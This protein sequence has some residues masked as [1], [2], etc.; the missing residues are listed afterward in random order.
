MISIEKFVFNP[1]QENTYVLYDHT[2]ECVIVDPGCIDA[3]EQ[4]MI[5]DFIQ[6]NDLRP[7]MVLNTHLHLDHVFGCKFIIDTY[8][9]PFIAHADDQFFIDIT[10]SYAVQ[11][12]IA[13]SENPPGLTKTVDEGDVVKFGESELQIIHVPGHSPGG[14]VLYNKSQQF[15]IAGDVLFNGSIGRTDLVQGNH[16]QLIS[17]IKEKLLTLNDDIIVY[18]GH[19]GVTTIGAEKQENPFLV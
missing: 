4:Q 1:F 7:V 11:F 13:I 8:N 17:G 19:G 16:E 3:N 15:A 9:I 6:K 5:V 12:G 14:I 10:K 18:P 2:K